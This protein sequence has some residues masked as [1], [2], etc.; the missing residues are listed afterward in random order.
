MAEMIK[1]TLSS[2][3]ELTSGEPQKAASVE[4]KEYEYVVQKIIKVICDMKRR[5]FL[6]LGVTS[7]ADFSGIPSQSEHYL[8]RT[9]PGGSHC[10]R[11]P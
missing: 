1:V 11:S 8:G 7:G 6:M 4:C 2:F 10:R 9:A 3:F 5:R